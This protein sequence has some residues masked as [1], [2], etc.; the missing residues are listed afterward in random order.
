[1]SVYFPFCWREDG[2][3][4]KQLL[5]QNGLS[6]LTWRHRDLS[7][8]RGGAQAPRGR[9]PPC[10]SFLRC[11]PR[12]VP[13]DPCLLSQWLMCSVIHVLG[14]ELCPLFRGEETRKSLCHIR[15]PCDPVARVS[16]GLVCLF[17]WGPHSQ[18]Q[19]CDVPN[20][21]MKGGD[22]RL[23]S[24]RGLHLC[25]FLDACVQMLKKVF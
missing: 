7:L 17:A 1:M 15:S 9:L 11:G 19:Q 6:P 4:Q 8:R 25:V 12:R 18:M 23:T 13:P 22:H 24:S 3:F 21:K 2:S 5:I 14:Q 16:L 20:A 10:G